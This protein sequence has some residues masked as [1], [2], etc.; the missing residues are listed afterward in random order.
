LKEKSNCNFILHE[1]TVKALETGVIEYKHEK[2]GNFLITGFEYL[3]NNFLDINSLSKVKMGKDDIIIKD[4][5]EGK[6]IDIEKQT[7]IK[8]FVYVT[9]GHA[10]DSISLKLKGKKN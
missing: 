9:R 7:G 8:G 5:D 10:K 3:I 1:G 4:S 6:E 2:Y